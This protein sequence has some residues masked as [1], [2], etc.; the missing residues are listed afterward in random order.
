ML[1]R[2]AALLDGTVVDVRL[3][4]CITEVAAELTPERGED[5]LDAAHGTL[6]PGLHDHHLHLRAAAAALESVPVGPPH[7]RCR[8]DVARALSCAQPDSDGW[9][10]AVGY[11][12]S[13][14]GPLDRAVLD[15]IS[16]TAPIRVQHRSGALW[17]LNTTGLKHIG[18]PDHPDGRLFRTG[19]DWAHLPPQREPSL[20]RV[21][22]RLLGFGVT[23]VTD[24]TPG[25]GAADVES[26]GTACRS[27]ELRQRL[28]CMAEV[29]VGA[30][31]GITVG[32]HKI[33]L[34]DDSLDLDRLTTVVRRCHGAR[35]PVAVHCVTDSQLVVT[36]A[37]LRSVGAHPLDRI[38][39]AAVVP[40]DVLDD[41]AAL[42]VTVVT[43]PNF[44]AERGDAYLVEIP[45]A[46]HHQ[47]WRVRSL[48]R[49][50]INVALSTD[51]PFGDGDPW[52]AMRAAVH[53]T[54]ASG[55]T[56]VAAERISPR[57]A[58]TMFLG[59]PDRPAEPRMVAP[60]ASADLCVLQPPPRDV[61]A[62]L[63]STMV[64]AT[65]IGGEIA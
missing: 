10:R 2:Q 50:H 56:L 38:E 4:R 61:L 9:I 55:A 13:V 21:S 64:T 1:I 47:L 23:G 32:P 36:L 12:E 57:A 18:L 22:R 35:R 15:E 40:D 54:T 49:H 26:L 17:I 62:A 51:M 58:L 63:D 59:R 5:V 6:I 19:G 16:P 30:S 3:G 39:H 27:G 28:H 45:R 37:A 65:I 24:A 44:V 8:D 43:Q 46:E 60:G 34:D 33:I 53:R 14:A 11:H 41:L 42:G 29:G 20:H 25:H 52:A 7:A 48:L 31:P